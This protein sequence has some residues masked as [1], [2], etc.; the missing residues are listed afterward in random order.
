MHD[1]DLS[2]GEV[3]A[4]LLGQVAPLSLGLGLMLLFGLADSWFA[5]RMGEAQLAA[6]ALGSTVLYVMS[7]FSHGIGQATAVLAGHAY[8]G[9]DTERLRRVVGQALALGVLFA[10]GLALLTWVAAPA[11]LGLLGG[12][13]AAL[14]EASRYLWA[15]LPGLPLFYLLMTLYGTLNGL[16]QS[17]VFGRA[18]LA[19]F[20][21]S[22]CLNGLASLGIG[23]LAPLGVTGLAVTGCLVQGALACWLLRAAL[24]L[25]ALRGWRGSDLRPTLAGCAELARLALPAGST[26]LFVAAGG[27][28]L[29]AFV[30]RFG[31]TAMAG[32][33]LGFRIE[34]VFLVPL[35]ALGYAVLG[36]VAQS[37]GA[38]RRARVAEALRVATRLGLWLA[39]ALSALLYLSAPWLAGGFSRDAGPAAVATDYLRI[40]CLG[41]FGY[42]LMITAGQALQGTQR[43][44]ANFLGGAGRHLVLQPLLLSGAVSG[45]GAVLDDVWWS[46]ALGCLI[47]GAVMTWSAHRRLRP[48]AGL[49]VT[50]P[51][52]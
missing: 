39:L 43:P 29:F 28:I 49:P 34:Q 7:A 47:T 17:R 37:H 2:R 38:G 50:D 20:A 25:P 16:G 9:K 8:A 33:L 13:D 1:T 23:P 18:L 15:A 46:V 12:R 26:Y 3:G 35:I 52:G 5:G 21:A 10:A 41:S 31:D 19:G 48:V 36:L 44:A 40:V 51:R 11:L 6:L 32:A 14:A 45:A 24:R 22:L 4:Q 30:G 42:A 27:Y